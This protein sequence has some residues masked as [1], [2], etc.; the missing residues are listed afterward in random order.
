MVGGKERYERSHRY[1]PKERP[2]N[3]G[4]AIDPRV[5]Q[6]GDGRNGIEGDGHVSVD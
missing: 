1:A 3:K 6:E 4:N 2:V 5:E